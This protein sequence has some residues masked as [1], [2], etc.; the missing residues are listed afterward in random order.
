MP[1]SRSPA[2]SATVGALALSAAVLIGAPAAAQ[3][4][5]LSLDALSP[6]QQRRL[7][8][9]VTI[10]AALTAQL[11]HCGYK[12]DMERR[13]VAAVAACVTQESLAKVVNLYRSQKAQATKTTNAMLG[14]DGKPPDTCTV[15]PWPQWLKSTNQIVENEIRMLA[16]MCRHC[17]I[18]GN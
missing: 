11:E 1:G 14:P 12:P 2:R 3:N 17:P 8:K 15:G 18:C 7:D 4:G 10:L 16:R 9:E 5:R 13:A 6:A